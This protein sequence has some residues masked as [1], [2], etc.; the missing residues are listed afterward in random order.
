MQFKNNKICYSFC[1][2][3]SLHSHS[4]VIQICEPAGPTM[5]GRVFEISV[6]SWHMGRKFPVF[7]ALDVAFCFA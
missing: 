7:S 2:I 6:A 1:Q 5:L 4:G 3:A